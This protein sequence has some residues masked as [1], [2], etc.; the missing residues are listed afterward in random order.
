MKSVRYIT[1]DEKVCERLTV[2]LST[3]QI[4]SHGYVTTAHIRRMKVVK[5]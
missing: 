4:R 3:H 2:I 1:F 5:Q